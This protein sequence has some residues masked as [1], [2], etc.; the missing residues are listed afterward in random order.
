MYRPE[1]RIDSSLTNG[2]WS[3][4]R[5]QVRPDVRDYNSPDDSGPWAKLSY[6]TI[7]ARYR[8]QSDNIEASIRSMR[9]ADSR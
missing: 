7:A 5:V 2:R 6:A 4:P 8:A 9:E 1:A 3:P